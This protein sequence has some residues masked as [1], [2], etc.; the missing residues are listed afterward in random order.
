[1]E[2]EIDIGAYEDP[3][4]F[5]FSPVEAVYSPSSSLFSGKSFTFPYLA[6]NSNI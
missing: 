3:L 1:L 5:V 2:D 4:E 6:L